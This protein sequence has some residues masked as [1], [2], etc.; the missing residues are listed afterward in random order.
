M[1]RR[2]WGDKGYNIECKIR[3]NT[4]EEDDNKHGI[5]D[6]DRAKWDAKQNALEFDEVPVAESFN[7]V[8][9]GGVYKVIK[10]LDEDIT[11]AYHHYYDV[12]TGYLQEEVEETLEEARAANEYATNTSDLVNSIIE[13]EDLRGPQGIQGPK[14]DTGDTGPK[15][16]KGDTGEQ[17]IQGIQGIQGLKGDTGDV[18]PKGDKGDKGDTGEGVQGERG[19][20]GEQGEQGPEG[21]QG[22]QGPEGPEGPMGPV[23]DATNK[24]DKVDPTGT[25][26]ISINRDAV[27]V[28]GNN[29]AAFGDG[30][31]ASGPS[32]CAAGYRAKATGNYSHAEGQ[33]SEASGTA[34]HAEGYLNKSTGSGSH[35]EGT[36]T[37]ATGSN[38]HTEGLN[39]HAAGSHTHSEGVGNTVSGNVDTTIGALGYAC[40]AEGYKT[41]SGSTS[42]TVAGLA[43]TCCHAEGNQTKA[44]GSAC[45]AEGYMTEASSTYSHAEGNAC[46]AT[47]SYTHAEGNNTTASANSAHAEGNSSVASGV[48]SHAE[49]YNTRAT[50]NSAHSEGASSQA[51][52]DYSH[53]G[54]QTNYATNYGMTSIGKFNSAPMAGGTEA[55]TIGSVFVIG[56]GVRVN[57]PENGN[58]TTQGNAFRVTY[59]GETY[60]LSAF[61][62]SG[63]DYAEYIKEWYDGNPDNE[64]RVGYL[65]TIKE[66]GLL[67]KAEA[68]DIVI[69]VTSGNPSV[70]GNADEDYY[71]KYERDEF[72]RIIMEDDRMKIREGY[73]PELQDNYVE[74]KDRKEWSCVGLTG[75]IPVRDDGSCVPGWVCKVGSAGIATHAPVRNLDTYLVVERINDNVVSVL[76]K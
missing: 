28:I 13:S 70:I 36:I 41:V 3:P 24:M 71:W 48:Y 46:K 16:D 20:K 19:E 64:D 30:C 22:E 2:Y 57:D 74:R 55:N 45:H 62:S 65:V 54:G 69:G 53:A 68:E 47:S 33:L 32:A 76:V 35:S 11:D 9:S 18:G 61:N 72:N 34:S 26:S 15:G 25:G 60:G 44:T 39:T 42:G 21:P 12:A 4:C 56:N 66:D 17:G 29:S 52:G 38:A 27:A 31:I 73:N 63:A 8:Y 58:T 49:G 10:E 7:P 1:A 51:T 50:G 67:H 40:H 5:T 14:G 59:T 6:E 75:I 37:L 43:G 23:G